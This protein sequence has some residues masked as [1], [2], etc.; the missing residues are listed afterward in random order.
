MTTPDRA[1]SPPS[2]LLRA[3]DALNT[4]VMKL[5]P[6]APYTV[7]RAVPISMRDGARLLAD[8]Y[9]PTGNVRGTLL[10]RN[11]YGRSDLLAATFATAFAAR[12][13]RVVLQSTRGTFGSGGG[14]FEPMAREVEDGADT[15]A[16]LR[17]QPW[18]DGTFATLGASYLGFTQWALLMD[19][20]PELKTAVIQIGVHDVYHSAHGAGAFRL[21]LLLS[22]F[23]S[24]SRQ[25]R[26]TLGL[27]I[28]RVTAKR[29]LDPAFDALPLLPAGEHHLGGGP[30][31]ASYANFLTRTNANDPYWKS[32]RLGEALERVRV[33]VLLIG[34]WQ[35]IF[36]DQT[37][38]QYARLHERGVDVA[39]TVGPWAHGEGNDVMTR[40]SLEWFDEHLGGKARRRA[41]PVRVFV[42]GAKTW[43]DLPA[44][45]PPTRPSTLYLHPGGAL[46][47]D[48]P[49]A[50]AAPSTFTYDPATPTPTIGGQLLTNG[51]YRDV[52][53]LSARADVLTF[54]SLELTE[55]LEVA[56]VPEVEL[57]H[58][59]DNPHADVFVRLVEVDARGGSRNVSDGFRRLSDADR[60]SS[61]RVALDA[62]AH[63]FAAGTRVRVLIS[64]GS[65]PQY[66]RNLGTGLDPALSARMA[67]SHRI[68]AHGEGGVSSLILPVTS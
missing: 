9:T 30:F 50:T 11:P 60:T 7:T 26:G 44:W 27:L 68:V 32:R 3:F 55:P 64:G 36:L 28:D 20:P 46:S 12:R 62:V 10:L 22:W 15:V 53:A 42:T 34:G 23:D 45:P 16:W 24:V 52:R 41:A 43:R 56:G 40:E 35:D 8:V 18:F 17:E 25:E 67:V 33:P 47:A 58:H 39:L 49:P 13:Y 21:D 6:G 29:R 51:G 2:R 63:R 37:L 57:A 4:R 66:A 61:V 31:A 5:P 19:P 38:T 54:T 48:P 59:S 65:H 14:P 1:A